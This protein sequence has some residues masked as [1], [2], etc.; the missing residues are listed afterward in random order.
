MSAPLPVDLPAELERAARVVSS[1][2]CPLCGASSPLGPR[3]TTCAACDTCFGPPAAFVDDSLKT[4]RRRALRPVFAT[5]APRPC[6]R[7]QGALQRVLVDDA[8][9]HFCAACHCVALDAARRGVLAAPVWRGLRAEARPRRD[10]PV[11]Q[12]WRRAKSASRDVVVGVVAGAVG[13]VVALW[14]V[15]AGVVRYLA[16]P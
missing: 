10:G 15:G 5:A 13:M 9:G 2:T 8:P 14:L 4:P 7:C 3:A 1:T 11:A 16:A 6:A 12:V